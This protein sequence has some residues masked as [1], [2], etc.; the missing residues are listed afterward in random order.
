LHGDRSKSRLQLNARNST[1]WF[2]LRQGEEKTV[3]TLCRRQSCYD[4]K[5]KVDGKSK[6]SGKSRKPARHSRLPNMRVAASAAGDNA[7]AVPPEVTS[8][9]AMSREENKLLSVLDRFQRLENV[10]SSSSS[11]S[12]SRRLG[13]ILVNKYKYVNKYAA[14][15]A[16]NHTGGNNTGGNNTGA[17]RL[18]SDVPHQLASFV[19]TD[20]PQPLVPPMAAAGAAG[21][22]SL[23]LWY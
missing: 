6:V 20:A 9:K 23:Q 22:T 1:S 3:M 13:A 12:S 17:Q 11:S 5:S 14:K 19:G 8:D 2:I 4:V 21:I 16:G 15:T 18:Q 7:V 10:A